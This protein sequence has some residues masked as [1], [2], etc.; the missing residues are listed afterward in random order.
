MND[1]SRNTGPRRLCLIC[2][3]QVSTTRGKFDQH[4]V[5][6]KPHQM[7]AGSGRTVKTQTATLPLD[8]EQ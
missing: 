4:T 7:C 1:Y 2:M 8:A 5:P 3:K 6:G